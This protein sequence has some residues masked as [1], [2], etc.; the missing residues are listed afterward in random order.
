MNIRETLAYRFTISVLVCASLMVACGTA[1]QSEEADLRAGSAIVLQ[2]FPTR[3]DFDSV[4]VT[5]VCLNGQTRGIL[6]AE[7]VG[8]ELFR[9]D[10][11]ISTEAY[12]GLW[13]KLEAESIWELPSGE[14][15]PGRE[16]MEAAGVHGG[17]G[18][19]KGSSGDYEKVE[20]DMS[21]FEVKVRVKERSHGFLRYA[22]STLKDRRYSRVIDAIVEASQWD[23]ILRPWYAKAPGHPGTGH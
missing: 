1:R 21:A 16:L 15:W 12:L 2:E 13:R 11:V 17:A 18:W 5:I 4:S 14:Y 22:P 9:S 10:V 20:M 19:A 7:P 6:R 23:Q 8:R 3:S